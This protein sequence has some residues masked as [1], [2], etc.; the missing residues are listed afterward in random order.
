LAAAV[1]FAVL[2]WLNCHAI[3]RWESEAYQRAGEAGFSGAEQAAEK[4]PCRS[5]HPEGQTSG[6]EAHAN[7]AAFAAR[8]KSCPDTK[9]SII[10]SEMSFSAA[11]EAQAD[12]AALAA[13]LKSCPDTMPLRLQDR[14]GF[15]GA[16]ALGV[17]ARM[18]RGLKPPPPSGSSSTAS[19]ALAV[20]GLMLACALFNT[21]PR[22]AA[23]VMAGAVSAGLLAFLDRFR[24]HLTPLALRV[25]AD[26][27]LL[28]PLALLV[29]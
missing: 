9:L 7:I 11:S 20:T 8:L 29:R 10:L 25:A 3:E 15:S 18:V 12:F 28:T 21:H 23:L 14:V 19:C 16:K 24:N 4:G 22:S 6:A 26:L 1:F 17:S 13:R 5:E 2:A 27:V